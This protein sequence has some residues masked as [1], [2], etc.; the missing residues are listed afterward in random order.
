MRESMMD[1]KFV[2]VRDGEDLRSR[3]PSYGQ[4]SLPI[5]EHDSRACKKSVLAVHSQRNDAFDKAH[6]I[7][8]YTGDD[9]RSFQ[10]MSVATGRDSNETCI[11]TRDFRRRLLA[12]I[13]S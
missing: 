5:V 7:A 3:P 9:F 6:M 12:R 8:R 1:A 13:Q 11:R 4:A 10:T 2:P